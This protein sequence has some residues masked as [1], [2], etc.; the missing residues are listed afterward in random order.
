MKIQK[1][2]SM[3]VANQMIFTGHLVFNKVNL[4]DGNIGDG[5][6]SYTLEVKAGQNFYKVMATQ[7]FGETFI[8]FDMLPSDRKTITKLMR[9]NDE[10]WIEFNH[11]MAQDFTNMT[12]EVFLSY[13]K[14][15]ARFQI[16]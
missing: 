1:A 7:D 11:K 6:T 12:R 14:H 8:N 3:L 10:I 15:I 16:N 5:Y 2:L 4:T 9:E 13:F